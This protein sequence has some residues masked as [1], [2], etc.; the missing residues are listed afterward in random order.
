MGGCSC[1]VI[2][3]ISAAADSHLDA[4]YD[5][6]IAYP[7][8]FPQNE[9]EL[10]LGNFPREVHFHIRRHAADSLPHSEEQLATW[11]QQ[12]RAACRRRSV[13]LF[14]A[15]GSPSGLSG[16]GAA[17]GGGRG[18]LGLSGYSYCY[19]LRS[20]VTLLFI[21]H[22]HDW[23]AGISEFPSL[24]RLK[25]SNKIISGVLGLNDTYQVRLSKFPTTTV[26]VP[27]FVFRCGRRKK[28]H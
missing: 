15:R 24:C 23:R 19:Q 6:S 10:L 2:L 14:V 1:F 22:L 26:Q 17:G 4:V 8:N 28:Q 13:D 7:F 21:V 20:V 27:G 9:P 3:R 25:V 16:L 5:I 11:C 12:V 18:A